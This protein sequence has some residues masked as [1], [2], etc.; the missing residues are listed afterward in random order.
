MPPKDN[1]QS[2]IKSIARK[3]FIQAGSVDKTHGT[4]GELR[5][6]LTTDKSFKE[7]AFLEIQGKPVPFYVESLQPTFDDGALLK[8]RDI[9]SVEKASSFVGRTLLIPIGKRKKSDLYAE[10]D[11]T[12]FNLIDEKLGDIGVVE[13]IEEYPNQLLIRTNY[14][15]QEVLIPAVEAFI[16]EVNEAKQT[17]Y[18]R[19]PDGLLD[20]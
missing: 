3:D 4:K 8:L 18:L 16:T 7:W 14:N 20:I 5:I 19:L 10:D 15:G 13:G 6:S 2:G 1:K 11:F 12:G 9:D 17:I